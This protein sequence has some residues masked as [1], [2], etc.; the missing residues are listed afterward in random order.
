MNMKKSTVSAA[1]AAAVLS[2]G[3]VGQ[4]A[5]YTSA[6]SVAEFTDLSIEVLDAAGDPVEGNVRN[7]N[8]VTTNTT[9]LNGTTIADSDSCAGTTQPFINDCN[10]APPRLDSDV[11]GL[12]I[13]HGENNFNLEGPNAAGN[14]SYSDSAI[15]TAQL[16][17]DAQTNASLI[18]ETVLNDTGA[19]NSSSEIQSTTGFTFESTVTEDGSLTISFDALPIVY[20]ESDNPDSILTIAESS[21]QFVVELVQDSGGTGLGVWAPNGLIDG[22]SELGGTISCIDETDDNTLNTKASLSS[23]PASD[24]YSPGLGS[25]ALTFDG[26]IAGDWT[27]SLTASVSNSVNKIVE[28]VPEPGTLLLLGAGLAGLGAIRRMKK[29][30]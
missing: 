17:G 22:C 7:F 8:F 11:Q 30:A 1:I 3:I 14:F 13:A 10:A 5:A 9:T 21:L 15:L 20:A 18:A 6:G 16:T 25:Y 4:A 27:L 19:G 2:A 24:V 29:K 23:D 26:L 12:G 28:Q